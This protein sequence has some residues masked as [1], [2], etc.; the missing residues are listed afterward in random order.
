M[1]PTM[2]PSGAYPTFDQPNITLPPP[3]GNPYGNVGNG[4]PAFSLPEPS[5]SMP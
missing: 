5:S 2:G 4:A 3:P 1:P